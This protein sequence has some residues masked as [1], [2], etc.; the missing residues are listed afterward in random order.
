METW[1]KIGLCG[2]RKGFFPD[3]CADDFDKVLKGGPWLIGGHF[4][5]IRP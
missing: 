1:G 4:L 3:N 2:S 5:A